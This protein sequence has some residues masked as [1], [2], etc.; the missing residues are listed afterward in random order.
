MATRGLA[1]DFANRGHQVWVVAPSYSPRDARSLEHKVRVYRFSS[2]SRT[3]GS[4]KKSIR[5][6][7]PTNTSG[8]TSS[9][10]GKTIEK[11][12][13]PFRFGREYR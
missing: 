8:V 10:S 7:P 2:S 11:N 12:S 1:E 4:R 9:I 6:L 13:R 3:N 5:P